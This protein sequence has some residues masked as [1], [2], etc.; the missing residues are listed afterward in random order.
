[1]NLLLGDWNCELFEVVS[2]SPG[3]VIAAQVKHSSLTRLK[4]SR[5]T[6][7]E[8]SPLG[9]HYYREGEAR[10]KRLAGKLTLVRKEWVSMA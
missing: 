9:E 6:S 5:M 4:H 8:P 10:I 3:R 7:N 1:M 2:S